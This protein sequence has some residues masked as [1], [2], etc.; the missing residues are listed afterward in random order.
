[1]ENHQI[2]LLNGHSGTGKTKLC[3]Y[4][5]Q[6]SSL[7]H[8]TITKDNSSVSFG[9]S[10]SSVDGLNQLN[11]SS[12]NTIGSNSAHLFK[13]LYSQLGCVYFCS[14][15]D[16]QTAETSQFLH[17][18]A[19]SLIN[20]EPLGSQYKS[21]LVENGNSLLKKIVHPYMCRLD[22]DLIL[23]KC[24]L[25]PIDTL[26]NSNS[27]SVNNFYVLIDGLDYAL[28]V[29]H[30]QNCLN[31]LAVFLS[32]NMS[33]FPKW[34]KLII[35][36][37]N[38]EW[39][40]KSSLTLNTNKYHVI[41]LDS[42]LAQSFSNYLNKD[43]NDY[44]IYR[45]NKSVDIQKNILYFNSSQSPSLNRYGTWSANKLDS[46]FQLKF[47]QHLSHL[48]ENNYLFIK[49]VLDLIAKGNLTIKNSNFK[50]LP[51]NFDHLVKLYFNLKFQ[52]KMSYEK[53]ACHIFTLLLCARRPLSLDDL[54]Q[55][56]NCSTLNS[57]KCTLNELMDQ[58][59]QIECFVSQLEYYE[60]ECSSDQIA[61]KSK[62]YIFSHAGLRDWW[63]DYHLKN[64][65]NLKQIYSLKWGYFLLG[66]NLFR[67]IEF[68]FKIDCKFE[69]IR[70]LIDSISYL[71]QSFMSN[72][73]L[74]YLMTVYMP[75]LN[76]SLKLSNILFRL[77]MSG[78]F[79]SWPNV[80][81]FRLCLQLG[82]DCNRTVAY[83]N[84][85]P[86][87]CVL[88]SLGHTHLIQELLD[89]DDQM[90]THDPNG[91]NCLCYAT[92]YEQIECA[93]FILDK[94]D[95]PITMITQLD[96][97]GLCALTYASLS[98][99]DHYQFLD[100]FIQCVQ[101]KMDL[102][103]IKLLIEQSMV[104]AASSGNLNCLIYLSNVI[105]RSCVCIDCVDSLK[106]ETPLSASCLN[107]HKLI[108][109]YL[110]NELGA[111]V[112]VCNARSWSPLLCAVKSGCW[113]IVEFLLFKNGHIIDLA[114]KNGRTPTI[115][116]ASEGHLAIIDILIEK[117]ADLNAQDRDGLSA[118][119][120]ACLKG[121]YNAASALLEHNIDVNHADQSGRTAL[122]LATFYGDVRLVQLLIDKGA[123]IE[124]VDKIGMRPLDRAIGCRNVPVVSCF[125]KKGAKLNPAT[126][127][128]AQGKPE[129]IITLLNKLVEDGNTLYRVII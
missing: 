22:P 128:M 23:K 55:S 87:I 36:V 103:S 1:M 28:S 119:S 102:H 25:D 34:L 113:E 47:V 100:L 52:S 30:T 15:D 90:N 49:L 3:Q 19:W 41:N 38:D 101:V 116:A 91:T 29:N 61:T 56:I 77:V 4:I 35:T 54:Y 43:L 89:H 98:K 83:F 53:L 51:K 123:Q 107:G 110:V 92:Q 129:I 10:G 73:L 124:H 121:H 106:G 57:Q 7:Y 88:A 109:E 45:L 105:K 24:I 108:C 70:L 115:L 71:Q 114:D 26:I 118:L 75:F 86:L 12:F 18:L 5:F 81:L 21:I 48:A 122:D 79:L 16:S 59:S 17:T 125:L 112:N 32:S 63:L 68:N 97:N 33:L 96:S 95:D 111:S 6:K 84:N 65:N 76:G 69:S 94:S 93:K 2:V 64:A 14:P 42:K 127:A 62:M 11:S 40:R 104:L 20:F 58:L 37:R 66:L 50:V 74:I 27:V 82:V 60:P 9:L 117:G 31:N 85:S 126:W 72:N 8:N 39:L 78:E 120:W 44:I 67:S 99:K 80:H 46:N 13:S